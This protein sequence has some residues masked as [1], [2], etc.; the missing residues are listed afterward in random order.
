MPGAQ[1]GQ[2]HSAP[3][4]GDG[5]WNGYRSRDADELQELHLWHPALTGAFPD[6]LQIASVELGA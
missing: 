4:A 2:S 1:R 5:E 6:P 3:E